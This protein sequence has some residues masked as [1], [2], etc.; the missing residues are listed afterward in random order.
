MS[1]ILRSCYNSSEYKSVEIFG[2]IML[3]IENLFGCNNTSHTYTV[4]G[5]YNYVSMFHCNN[6]NSYLWIFGGIKY[7]YLL[8][9]LPQNIPRCRYEWIMNRLQQDSGWWLQNLSTRAGTLTTNLD[10]IIVWT[11][12]KTVLILSRLAIG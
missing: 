5:V 3:I 2:I 11:N 4:I 8:L 12:H 1:K 10:N 6:N 9:R 7:Q